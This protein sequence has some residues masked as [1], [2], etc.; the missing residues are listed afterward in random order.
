MTVP[1][2]RPP[3]WVRRLGVAA[4]NVTRT[5]PTNH[6]CYSETTSGLSRSA[7]L[8]T[9]RCAYARRNPRRP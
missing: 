3:S 1:P 7:G 5:A 9:G 8:L 6:G 4:K 2:V